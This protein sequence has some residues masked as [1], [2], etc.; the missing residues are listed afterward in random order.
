MNKNFMKIYVSNNGYKWFYNYILQILI[1][2]KIYFYNIF[3]NIKNIC[4]FKYN[5]LSKYNN[6]KECKL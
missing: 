6:H 4:L 2:D 5:P 3:V 1:F